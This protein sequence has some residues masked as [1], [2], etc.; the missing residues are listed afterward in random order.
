MCKDSYMKMDLDCTQVSDKDTN[1]DDSMDILERIPIPYIVKFMEKR[2]TSDFAFKI[3][4]DLKLKEIEED[5]VDAFQI[6]FDYLHMP[7]SHEC[8][9]ANLIVIDGTFLDELSGKEIRDNNKQ[10]IIGQDRL[11][12]YDSL[13]NAVLS[14]G[15][16]VVNWISGDTHVALIDR[17]LMMTNVG[18][19]QV[20]ISVHKM[21]VKKDFC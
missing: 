2:F 18:K 6:T 17:N 21:R 11:Y 9:T 8:F 5:M 7:S 3:A 10:R 16:L 1:L 14:Q 12:G 19:Y 4:R 20:T 13:K 15:E